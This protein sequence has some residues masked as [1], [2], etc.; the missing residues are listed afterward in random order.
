M[1]PAAGHELPEDSFQDNK[2]IPPVNLLQVDLERMEGL[3]LAEMHHQGLEEGGQGQ[4]H[5]CHNGVCSGIVSFLDEG[6]RGL[7]SLLNGVC[8]RKGSGEDTTGS[9]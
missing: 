7:V 2:E 9:D 3:P 8:G 1:I 5:S 6:L 4:V